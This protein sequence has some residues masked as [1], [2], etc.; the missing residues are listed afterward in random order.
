[1]MLFAFSKGV[2]ASLVSMTG[3]LQEDVLGLFA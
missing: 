1:L 2:R 3:G